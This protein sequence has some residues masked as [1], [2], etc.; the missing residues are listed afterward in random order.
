MLR[1]IG[2]HMFDT[3]RYPYAIHK[4]SRCTHIAS[5]DRNIFEQ[6]QGTVSSGIKTTISWNINFC[7]FISCY[8]IRFSTTSMPESLSLLTFA[9]S[10][11]WIMPLDLLCTLNVFYNTQNDSSYFFSVSAI[12]CLIFLDVSHKNLLRILCVGQQLNLKDSNITRAHTVRS[13]WIH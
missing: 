9:R 6:P 10:L 4:S 11:D 12:S 2:Y 5:N 13:R 1:F 7:T 8:R 3:W